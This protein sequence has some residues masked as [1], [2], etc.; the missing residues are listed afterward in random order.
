MRLVLGAGYTGSRVAELAA[1]RG[2]E[3]LATVRS[4]ERHDALARKGTF[5]VT[6]A[7]V[8]E[9][10]ER[11]VDDAARVVICFPPDGTTDDAL[12]PLLARARSVAYV[13]NTGVYGD[14]SGVI[15]DATPLPISPT[16]TQR[17]V[18]RA[19]AAYRA[20]GGTVLRAPGIYGPDRGLHIRVSTGAHRLPGDGSGFISRIHVDDLAA[21]LLASDRVRGE[22]FVVGDL[23]PAAQREIVG[24]ICAEYQCP[25][26]ASVPL[27]EVH[28]TLRRNRRI[29]PSRARRMLDITLRYPTYREGMRLAST[30]ASPSPRR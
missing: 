7:S 29:D 5:Q 11:F 23:A 1:G 2:E 20:V 3:V 14:V 17:R 9:V 25:F 4:A 24:W 12:A 13:S 28:E 8:L 19:E 26:P 27:E 22:T 18:L 21:M 15:D 16:D 30:P 10:A 6:R